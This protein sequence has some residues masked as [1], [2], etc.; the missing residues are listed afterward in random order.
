MAPVHPE[1]GKL[2]GRQGDF[3]HWQLELSAADLTLSP[4]TISAQTTWIF[5]PFIA[6]PVF[7]F[8]GEVPSEGALGIQMIVR[9]RPANTVAFDTRQFTLLLEDGRSLSPTAEVWR[10]L[11]DETETEPPG[12]V[13]LSGVNWSRD[14]QY[15]VLVS[16]LAPFALQLGT[17]T[18][19]GQKIQVPPIRF[20]HGKR[21]RSS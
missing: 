6:F 4:V 15:D 19:N 5:G 20:V 13:T 1:T 9:V 16:E 3:D 11:T 7:L 14:L 17:L 10:P 21:Y 8:E 2:Y 18:V 12:P